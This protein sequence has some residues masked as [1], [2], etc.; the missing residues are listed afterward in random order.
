[1][2]TIQFFQPTNGNL[3]GSDKEVRGNNKDERLDYRPFKFIPNVKKMRVE[4][5]EEDELFKEHGI[6]K[7]KFK[8]RLI[9]EKYENEHLNRYARH[10]LNRLRKSSGKVYWVIA[11]YLIKRSNVFFIL[12]L[13]HVFPKWSREIGL[14]KVIRLA[15]AVRRIA[16]S[17]EK[18]IDSSRIYISKS[19]GKLRPLGV[20]TPAWRIYLH[21]FNQMLVYYLHTKNLFHEDQHGF[22]PGRG[23]K[24]AWESILK[25]VLHSRDIYEF[26]LKNFFDS[27]NLDYISKILKKKG[28]PENIIDRIYFLNTSQVMVK[29]QRNLNEFENFMKTLLRK[30]DSETVIK[31]PRPIGFAYRVKGVPQGSPMSPVLATMAL[32][33]SIL[34]R[35]MKT[36][37]YADDGL[38]YG[39]IDQPVITPNSGIIESNIHFNLDKTN[40]VKRD[41]EWLKPLKFLGMEFNGTTLTSKTRGGSELLYDKDDL[42]MAEYERRSGKSLRSAN[43]WENLV[44]SKLFGLI[45]SRMYCGT[46]NLEE[47]LQDFELDYIESSFVQRSKDLLTIYNYSSYASKWLS[48]KLK[49]TLSSKRFI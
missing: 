10:Q 33:N 22:R 1:M 46:W 9:S 42:I 49:K 15:T 21:M 34:D 23:T 14:S 4:I 18:S 45:Q 20:P 25:H 38:Y 41:G 47:I 39:N 30:G 19:N 17:T 16:W 13:N 24:T 48:R 29:S 27:V 32:E 36:L 5:S 11:T 40:W 3:P 43:T 7:N 35:G 12:G 6:E 31:S 2:N 37:M 8:A 28:I 44:K 26:D